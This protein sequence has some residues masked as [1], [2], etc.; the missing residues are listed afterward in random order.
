MITVVVELEG[1]LVQGVY[2]T[3]ELRD[4]RVLVVDKDTEGAVEDDLLIVPFSRL[5]P[6]GGNEEQWHY[7]ETE[8]DQLAVYVTDKSAYDATT[9]YIFASEDALRVAQVFD[10]E[11]AAAAQAVS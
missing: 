4:V 7:S 10:R 6:P 1:G 5:K 3:E 11:Q 8:T 2:A 9:P